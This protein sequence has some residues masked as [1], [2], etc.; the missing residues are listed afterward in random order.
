MTV[1][2]SKPALNL[3]EELASLRNQGASRED[4]LYLD[5][6][7]TNGQFAY[8]GDWDLVNFTISGGKATHTQSG[9]GKLIQSGIGLIEGN[10]YVLKFDVANRTQGNLYPRLGSYSN[11]ATL[12]SSA[13]GSHTYVV[14]AQSDDRIE[15]VANS[16]FDG[17]IDNVSVYEAGKNLAKNGEFQASTVNWSVEG[18]AATA[19]SI[20][21]ERLKIDAA[22]SYDGAKQTLSTIIGKTYTIEAEYELGTSTAAGLRLFG[23]STTQATA[24][25]GT[26]TL[27]EVATITAPSLRLT[28]GASTG[29]VFFKSVRVY[30]GNHPVIQR[31]S[32][33]YDVKDVYIDGELA[34]EGEGYDYQ[35]KTD[36]IDQ[37]I[38]LEVEPTSATETVVIGVRK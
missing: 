31:V 5:G 29:S 19:L 22:T 15:F 13:N 25:S 21:N 11:L 1:N 24:S 12:S 28:S 34:R 7:V 18:D 9:T 16:G 26:I 27:T 33:A 23:N 32:S 35:V 17:E 10:I 20:N 6:L 2:I 30:E 4:K 38:K 3:R 37:W 14:E 36:G 8:D